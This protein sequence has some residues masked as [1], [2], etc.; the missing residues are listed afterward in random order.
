[1]VDL[2]ILRCLW[3]LLPV[4]LLFKYY[5]HKELTASVS[6]NQME[7]EIV[8]ERDVEGSLGLHPYL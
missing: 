6:K 8:I 1:M 5:E 7:G 3:S 4:W 2:L